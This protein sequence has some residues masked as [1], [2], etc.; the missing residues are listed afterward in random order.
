MSA[1][2]KLSPDA[3]AS[4]IAWY[5]QYQT[6]L[7]QLRKLGSIHDKARAHGTSVRTIH[8]IVKRDEYELRRKCKEAGIDLYGST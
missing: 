5:A 8:N 7:E 4:I 1:P 2:R 6:A 3:E